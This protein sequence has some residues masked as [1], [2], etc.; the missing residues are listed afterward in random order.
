VDF[1]ELKGIDIGVRIRS[2]F[3]LMVHLN[4]FHI[5]T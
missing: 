5:T 1:N 3:H 2:D 4:L